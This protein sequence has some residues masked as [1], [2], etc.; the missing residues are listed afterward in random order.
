MGNKPHLIMLDNFDSFTYNLLDYFLVLGCEVTVVR[1]DIAPKNTPSNFD[2]LVIS[3][4]PGRPET[5]G[6]LM[7]YI[8]H[9][10]LQ[11]P[12]FGVCLGMQAINLYCGGT[13]RMVAPVH[14][15]HDQVFHHSQGIY[16]GIGNPMKVGR[17]HSL[18]VDRVPENLMISAWN[19]DGISM[20]LEDKN[21]PMRGVQFHPESILSIENNN[22][23]RLLANVLAKD[24]QFYTDALQPI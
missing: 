19:K 6:Y 1:N 3:P 20:T 11:K 18:A 2:M 23:M 17:Y 22:G 8:D 24:L 13:L 14:G 15:K 10:Y 9:Y 21:R 7:S 12:I 4:G 16:K 5:A